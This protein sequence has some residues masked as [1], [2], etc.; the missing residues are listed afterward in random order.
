MLLRIARA[1]IISA[2]S[3]HRELTLMVGVH[4]TGFRV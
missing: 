3:H 2:A 1:V 4:N